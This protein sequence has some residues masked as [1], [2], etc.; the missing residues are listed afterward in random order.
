MSGVVAADVAGARA[1]IDQLPRPLGLVPTMG[2]LHAGHLSLVAAARS[3]CAAVAVSIFVNPLQFGPREDLDAYPRNPDRDVEMLGDDVDV[4]FLPSADVFTP[5]DRK[6]NVSVST[7][8]DVL[9]GSA[10]PGHFDGVT[11]IVTKLFNVVRPDRAYFGEKDFQQL[12]IIRRMVADLD[13]PID[14]VGCPI[15][16]ETDGL[17]MSSRNVYLSPHQRQEALALSA[18]LTSAAA[19]W[20]GNADS[21]RA[22]LRR[23][24]DAAPGVRLDYAE[25]IDPVTLEPLEG[26]VA[27]PAQAVVAAWVGTTRLIDNTRLERAPLA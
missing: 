2:A 26:V 8:T 14:I 9:E 22:S 18:A 15:V 1:V 13:V 25:V 21:A 7:L 20:E 3:E 24:L 16:R 19:S 27:G 5:S 23:T 10:R 6:T 12:A 11:T 4:I 17:A